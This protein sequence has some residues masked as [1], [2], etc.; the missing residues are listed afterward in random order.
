MRANAENMLLSNARII[1]VL[2]VVKTQL[3]D[4]R[5]YSACSVDH[6]EGVPGS[7]TFLLHQG[8]Q[9]R[10]AITLVHED[11]PEIVWTDIRELVVGRVRNTPDCRH[12]GDVEHT[13]LSLNLLPARYIEQLDDDRYKPSA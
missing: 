12:S 3:F 2:E 13:I 4:W 5:R 11:D 6:G 9:R 1:P 7:G 8:I 10:I